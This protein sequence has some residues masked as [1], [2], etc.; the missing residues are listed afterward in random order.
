MRNANRDYVLL[1]ETGEDV[2]PEKAH[3]QRVSPARLFSLS[4]GEIP[5]LV[6]AT[7]FLLLSSLTQVGIQEVLYYFLSVLAF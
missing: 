4:K 7:V 6:L 3:Q 2:D 5:T 1:N